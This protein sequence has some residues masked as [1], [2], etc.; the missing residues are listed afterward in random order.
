[1]ESE[2][3]KQRWAIKFDHT[4]TTKEEGWTRD[5]LEEADASGCD[6]LVFISI[7][8]GNEKGKGAHN[9][10]VSY[11]FLSQDGHNDSTEDC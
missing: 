6:A 9:G 4:S 10:S 2:K 5:E 1:M 7:I 8:R 3:S 11:A